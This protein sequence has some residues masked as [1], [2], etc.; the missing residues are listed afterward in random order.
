MAGIVVLLSYAAQS[1]S[2]A[3]PTI[4]GWIPVHSGSLQNQLGLVG[5]IEASG[6]LT[7]AAPFA[8]VIQEV[9]VVEGQRVER[10]QP[11]LVLDT[12][13]LDIVLREALAVQLKLQRVVQDLEN[14]T[15][16]EEV[17]RARRS[18]TNAQYGLADTERKLADTRRLLDRGIVAR[19]EV[20]SLE[21]QARIQRLDM[22]ASQSELRAVLQKGMGEN[23]QIADMEL[24]NARSRYQAL[25]AVHANRELVAPFAGIVL[26]PQKSEGAAA[27]LVQQGMRLT[28]GA[29]LFELASLERI[30]AVARVEEADL[31]Q[32][33]EGMPVQVT[34][35]GFEGVTLQGSV[36][37][38]AAQGQAADLSGG[39]ATYEVVVN[40]EP[41]TPEQQAKVRLGMSARL[42]ITTY[43]ASNS[44]AIP[45]DALHDGPDGK[46][47]VIYR[48][49]MTEE[50]RKVV[51]TTGRATAEGVEVFG[52]QAGYVELPAT[53]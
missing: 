46:V 42:A 12:S 40:I 13:Q 47:S 43:H 31:H 16:G 27:P 10:G 2:E 7:L 26:R 53:R 45:A 4:N 24:A 14:W 3:S 50:P 5:R 51:V 49:N 33:S 23:R 9:A 19:M 15:Q 48:S 20:D 21:Q 34:G 39:G 36:A 41:L 17:A 29:P 28:E 37:T 38:I 18:V 11:L 6:R 8:G 25:Q 22:A 35:D 32:I 52:I 44:F 1:P 30:R